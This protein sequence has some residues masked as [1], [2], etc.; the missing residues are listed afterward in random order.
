MNSPH[1]NV[2]PATR[3]GSMRFPSLIFLFI[4][5]TNLLFPQGNPI[6]AENEMDGAPSTEWDIAGYAWNTNGYGDPTIQGFATPFSINTG[7]TVSFKIDVPEGVLYNIRIYRIGYYGGDGARLI[8]NLGNFTGVAQP[9]PLYQESTGMTSCTNWSV[10]ATWTAYDVDRSMNAVSGVYIARLTRNDTQGASHIVFIVRNDAAPSDILFK[11]ADGTWQAYNNY[12]G[13]NFYSAGRTITGFTHAVKASYDRPFYTRGGGGWGMGAGNWLFNAEYPMIRW[14]ERNGYNVTYTT[15]VDM[16]NTVMSIIPEKHKMLMSVGHDEYWSAT[17]RAN[18]ETARVN[19]VHLGFFSGNEV[20]WKTRWE[21][22]PVYGKVMVCYK[23]GTMG[24]NTCGI[25]CD[26][27]PIWTGL[28]RATPLAPA[29]G[30]AQPENALTGQI[31]WHPV[32]S[33]IQVP[34]EYGNL[35]FWRHTSVASLDPGQTAT[36]PAGTLGYEMDWEQYFEYYP[37]GR[38]TMSRTVE[39]G[40][41]HKLSL[42][43]YQSSNA[44]VFGAGTV[45]WSWGLDGNHD[46]PGTPSLDM[47]QA[48]YNLLTDMGLTP[49]TKQADLTTPTGSPDVTKP[50]SMISAPA[51][52]ATLN[53]GAP[54]IISGTASDAGG[55]VVAGVDVSVDGGVTW[56]TATGTYSW[57]FNWIPY[58]EGSATVMVRAFDDSGNIESATTNENTNNYTVGP[59]VVPDCPC[60]IWSPLTVPLNP[61]EA[62]ASAVELGVKFRAKENGYIT[63]I[64]FYK[65]TQ[66]TGTHIGNLWTAAGQ[67]L[68]R[69]TF[70]N[71]TASG[72][73]QV[74]FG[75]PVQVA[76]NEI[77][78]ASYHCPN[79]HYAEDGNYFTTANSPQYTSYYLSALTDGVSGPNGVYAFS[80][81]TTFPANGFVQSNYWVDVVF[82]KDVGPD[83]NPPTVLAVSPSDGASGVS[84]SVHPIATFNE[85]LDPASVNSGT[86]IMT[87]PSGPVAGTV[88]L[89]GSQIT[90]TPSSNLAYSTTYT[91]VLSG[92]TGGIRDMAATP[93]YLASDY[94]WSFTTSAPP[95]PPPTEGPGG[96]ILV[97]SSATNPFSRYPVEILR[98]EGLNAF[99]AMDVSLVTTAIMDTCAVIILGEFG[100]TDAFAASLA[101]WVNAGGTLIAFRP[102]TRLAGLLGIT[103]AGSTLSDA[104]LLVNTSSGPGVGIVSETIQF[105]SAADLYTLNGATSI[106]LLYSDAT[107]PTTHPAVTERMVGSSGGKAYAFTYDLAKSVVYTHQGNPAWAGQKRDGKI[108]PIRSDD[109]FVPPLDNSGPGWIDLDK[110]AIPQADEQQKL[111]ANIIIRGAMNRKVLPRFWFLPKGLKAAIVMSGDNHGDTGM[112][113]RFNVDISM[114]PAGCRVDE[115][116]CVRSTGYFFI[117]SSYTNA[118]AMYYNSLGFESALHINTGCADFTPAQFESFVSGQMAS[119]R[120]TFPGVPEPTTNRNHCIA[121]S[122]WSTVAEVSAA[123]GIRL[124]V[125]YYYWPNDWHQ[126][127][128]GM[129]TGS[130]NPMRFAKLDGTMIDVY[131][132]ST[133]MQDEGHYPPVTVYPAFCDELLD[134]AVGPKGYYGVFSANMHFDNHNHAGANAITRSAQARGVPVVSAKQMLTWLDG[135][136]GSTFGKITWTNDGVHYFSNFNVTVGSGANNLRGMLPVHSGNGELVSLT[137]NGSSVPFTTEVIKGIEYAFFAA[138]TGSYT[139]TYG[140]DDIAPV[141]S[142]V[143]A[144]PAADGTAT[145]T[146]TT[147]EASGSRVDYGTVSGELTMNMSA[148]AMV[149]THTVTL[150]GLAP[151][152]TY[153]FRVT[154]VDDAANSTS[155]PVAPEVLSFNTPAGICAQDRTLADFSLGT[156]DGNTQVVLDG[157]GA[158]ILRPG[159]LEEFSGTAIPAGWTSAQY[160]AGSGSVTVAGGRVVVD[161]SYLHTPLS[162]GP[163]TILE[164]VATFEAG[165]YQNV[166]F[167][168]GSGFAAPWVAIGRGLTGELFARASGQTDVPLGTGLLGTAHNYKIKWNAGNFEFFVDGSNTPAAT[169]ASVITTNMNI[170]ISDHVATG[171][172]LSVDWVRAT[173]YVGSGTFVSRVFDA[174]ISRTWGEVFWTSD[175]PESTSLIISARTGNTPVPDGSWTT[176]VP[177]S[178]PGAVIGLTSRYIQYRAELSTGN[179]LSTPALR[180]ISFSCTNAGNS[181]PVITVHPIS[182]TSCIG[183]P[184]TFSS[185]AAG[186]PAPSVHWEY[187]SNGG[188]GWAVVDGALSGTLTVEAGTGNNGYLYRA[189]W[190]NDILPDA[191]SNA[192]T[193]TVVPEINAVIEAVDNVICEGEAV[194]LR[195]GGATTGAAPYAL[196][197][198]GVSYAAN[199]VGTVFASIPVTIYSPTVTFD[200]TS[201]TDNNGCIRTGSPLS[202]VTVTVNPLPDGTLEAAQPSFFEGEDIQLVFSTTEGT[203]PFDLVINGCQYTGIGGGVQ[204][205]VGTAT[206]PHLSIW[207]ETATGGSQTADSTATELA[208]RFRAST[209]G[210]INGIRFY[211]HGTGAIL[212]AGRLWA[213]GNTTPLASANLTTDNTPGWKVIRFSQ[214]V[215]ISANTEYLASYSSPSRY[216]YA[217]TNPAVPAFPIT[218]GP[219][220]ALGCQ[221]NNVPGYP[222]ST[223]SANYWVDVEFDNLTTGATQYSLTTVTDATG[224]TMNGYPISTASVLIN[225]ARVW[226]GGGADAAW[227]TP[228][229]WLT[230]TV[231]GPDEN[232]VIPQ[233]ATHYPS[234]T[235]PVTTETLII[236]PSASMTVEAGGALTVDG[237]LTTTGASFTINSTAVNNSGSLIVNGT[238]TGNVTYMRKMPPDLYRYI[239]L[240]VSSS[241]FPS[242]TFWRWN[243]V[244][245]YWG[246]SAAEAPTTV[247]VSGMGYTVLASDN[248]LS[249]TGTVVREVL[250]LVATAPYLTPY[251][252]NRTP[253]GGGGWNLLGNPF[254][255][256]MGGLEFIAHNSASLDDSYQA[257]YIYNG[258]TYSYIAGG[259][260]IPGFPGSG[261][262]SGNDVQAGQGFFVLAHHNGVEF[263][264]LSGMRK[265]NTSEIMT[266]SAT[267]DGSWPGLQ[268]KVK[269][270]DAESSALIVYNEGMTTGIDPGYD[271]GLLSSGGDVEIY[272]ALVNG[273]SDFWY[274]RQALPTGEAGRIRVP[275]GLDLPGGGEV[276]FSAFTVTAGNETFWLEDKLAGTFTDLGTKSYTV[277]MPS[278]TYGTGR[279]YIIASANTP[280]GLNDPETGSGLRIWATGGRIII[281][282]AVSSRAI[283]E[284]FDVSGRKITD[285]KLTDGELNTVELVSHAEGVLIVRVTDGAK[286]TVQKV[287]LL[288]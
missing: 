14:L 200:L 105:H 72:W 63:G 39:G 16:G 76:A 210:Y 228:Q 264:F 178:A 229:N 38:V 94:T 203:G 55:G 109:M 163:G 188:T 89:A 61:S 226:T 42:Y 172:V 162:Y 104:Y 146:W 254:P 24:E 69:A 258:E 49:A 82:V 52:G 18:F 71:E 115:W 133:P 180:D 225:R 6:P 100:L 85:W 68:A 77:Y 212:F 103:P 231:P 233:V 60:T 269:R 145:I 67:N 193:L 245:G 143:I 181:A 279:F 3:A 88:S 97:I 25:K 59:M 151:T 153:Y 110:V 278:D 79:G 259:G 138:A 132:V 140:I 137:R 199:G 50:Y 129:F 283:C 17:A 219:L 86:V 156:P 40:L 252:Q 44:L 149:T 35:R 141:I 220:T 224:C 277:T 84:V 118:D 209:D 167:A 177:V 262:F 208:L 266:K 113:P 221:Y 232:V 222:G 281:K 205:S 56:Q 124:D 243:E 58:T 73:Q 248:T 239:S 98:A 21:D 242:G 216:Y 241:T 263:D 33:A 271:I 238:V 7:E 191:V 57:T 288:Q 207:P 218:S 154:S 155:E 48:T 120:S 170:Q 223:F 274:T 117:G 125:N 136:N 119:F 169:I 206:N 276:T 134:N 111:L 19:G 23:E 173:P 9:A 46:R 131:Q 41:T 190:H 192:A 287:T 22:D 12:G 66:N 2:M 123:H 285:R 261:T 28:W 54:V 102:D 284:V 29:T 166:G 11:T 90:F 65:G 37:A 30:P 36:M 47:Q 237:D 214:P 189:V 196:V 92:G 198:N 157:D 235:G 280:T 236:R 27:T 96:P 127:R 230:S 51:E 182:Q 260:V 272:T 234:V 26:P 247:S 176:F 87:G 93:N 135:R 64:R 187:S 112:V 257:L 282:G 186:S 211:K 80:S 130:G 116:E 183:S 201:V 53:A 43:R 62:D 267:A 265:H 147:D 45:Q 253:W 240:P 246:E 74:I 273:N 168:S 179:T 165:N 171:S 250:N 15:H 75:A 256:A 158:V 122:D 215:P 175:L 5:S 150:S 91:M 101:T 142:D 184:V 161:G 70:V 32:E 251:V 160:V 159:Y 78:V 13:N 194:E 107:T 244:G 185:V 148:G 8:A 139:G 83:T 174:T 164:F 275:V 217:F 99:T 144:T 20:Y 195:L 204:F 249:F 128:V 286:V 197:I 95:P 81:S 270:G 268:L 108:N 121:W 126:N 4:L 213:I 31:S 106:A 34:A 202:R 114:S 227:T 152:T 1:G 10:S 255:S